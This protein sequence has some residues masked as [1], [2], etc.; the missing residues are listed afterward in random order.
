MLLKLPTP[1]KQ[2]QPVIEL[3]HVSPVEEQAEIQIQDSSSKI[4]GEIV[5]VNTEP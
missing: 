4:A 2:G 1:K 3:S 5:I